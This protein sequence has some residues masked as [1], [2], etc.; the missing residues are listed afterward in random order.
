[1]DSIHAHNINVNQV[2]SVTEFVFTPTYRTTQTKMELPITQLS[3]KSIHP[4]AKEGFQCAP[5]P[6]LKESTFV[7]SFL[8]DKT[9]LEKNAQTTQNVFL[10][11]AMEEYA[12][13]STT[14]HLA[15]IQISATLDIIAQEP[16]EHYPTQHV[17]L[18]LPQMELANSETTV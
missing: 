6:K 10:E 3:P 7:P 18:K 14:V 4:S 11:T 9:S 5:L 1:M 2:T 17:N 13:E 16:T 8:K 15:T 12:K